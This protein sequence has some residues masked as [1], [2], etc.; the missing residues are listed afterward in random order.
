M[1]CK[2]ESVAILVLWLMILMSA[3]PSQ[4][5]GLA[6]AA[7]RNMALDGCTVTVNPCSSVGWNGTNPGPMI[8]VAQG[9]SVSLTLVSTDGPPHQFAVDVD[10]SGNFNCSVDKC[11]G[12]FPPTRTDLLT[13]DFPSDT[14]TYYCTV[15]LFNMRGTFVVTA[16]PPDF[17]I[18][19]SPP[20]LTIVQESSGMST[21][22]LTSVNSFSG[23]VSF[24][25][26]TSPTGPTTTF[27]INPVVLSAGGTATSTLTLIV[28][29]ATAVGNYTVTVTGTSGSLSHSVSLSITVQSYSSAS[30]ALVPIL[31]GAVAGAIVVASA[32]FYLTRRGRS[33]R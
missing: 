17:T 11:S 14:Y 33:K 24:S 6:Q 28:P 5:L 19:S 13:I 21:L 26:A 15:H 8:T 25:G 32:V 27:S 10:K 9:D 31:I 3:F 16:P 2:L 1:R 30:N 4:R 23:P 18:A 29:S 20:S 7:S 22:T 12:F